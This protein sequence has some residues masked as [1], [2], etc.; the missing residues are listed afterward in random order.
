MVRS[1]SGGGFLGDFFKTVNWAEKIEDAFEL[2]ESCEEI[3][4]KKMKYVD[5]QQVYQCVIRDS[6]LRILG[7]AKADTAPMAICLAYIAWRENV[8][9]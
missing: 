8:S 7:D 1:H 5:G 2:F 3:Y 4:L 9:Q 6:D